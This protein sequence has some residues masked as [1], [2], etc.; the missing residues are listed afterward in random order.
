MEDDFI[1]VDGRVPVSGLSRYSPK[2]CEIIILQEK[3]CPVLFQ[4]TLCS[5]SKML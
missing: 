5:V 4:A 3:L 2:C 1:E